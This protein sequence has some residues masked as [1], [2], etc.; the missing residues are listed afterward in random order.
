[1]PSTLS[2]IL[3]ELRATGSKLVAVSKTHPPEELMPLYLEGQR[4][5]GENRIQEMA[6]KRELMP[7]DIRWHAIGHLQ[8]NKVKF[9]A[10]FVH[11]IHSVDSLKLLQEIDR[12]AE[13]AGR[14]IPCLL[15]MHIAKEETKFGL[16]REELFS[17][18]RAPEFADMKHVEIRGL[19]G[20]ATLTEDREL[21]RSE[22]R[23]MSVLLE[24][25]Q[26]G[27]FSGK[28]S[29]C[30]LSMGMSSDYKIALEEGS[31]LV[32]IGSLLFG[33]RQN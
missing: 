4:D 8:T 13:K 19:M 23:M 6:T 2:T 33:P 9:I 20:M 31:T 17:L 15:Q 12:Q 14:V 29:F 26:S 27:F 10:P 22:F 18:L 32:R 21:I 24:E 11:L 1:M 25:L 5:F 7:K 28:E 30:E 16:D 3:D